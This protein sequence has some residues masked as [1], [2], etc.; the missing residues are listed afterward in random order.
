MT[1]S[2]IQ[3]AS[4]GVFRVPTKLLKACHYL[5]LNGVL[6]F[7][8]RSVRPLISLKLT[9]DSFARSDLGLQ[10]VWLQSIFF[11]EQ[12]TKQTWI[13]FVI[14]SRD[15][16]PKIFP[17]QSELDWSLDA[18][19]TAPVFAAQN[20][21]FIYLLNLGSGCSAAVEVMGSNPAGR[22]AF[23]RLNLISSVSLIR[24]LMEV[25]LLIFLKKF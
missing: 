10:W 19:T 24:S 21:F 17:Y 14:W 3:S 2:L 23:S 18:V 25:H 1:S 9:D 22:W 7:V 16:V 20:N 15:S 13:E 6:R 4:S 11:L 8:N 12:K 5:S